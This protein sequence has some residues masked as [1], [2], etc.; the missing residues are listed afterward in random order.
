MIGETDI[1]MTEIG[2]TTGGTGGTTGGTIE[3]TGT[4]TTVTE[5][6][7]T[8]I[9]EIATEE[10]TE[11]EKDSTE[12]EGTVTEGVVGIEEGIGGTWTE[13]GA[14]QVTL[15]FFPF[16][17]LHLFFIFFPFLSLSPTSNVS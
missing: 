14:K 3:G 7:M 15:H 4:G 5:E 1:R 12:T 2:K 10:R 8:E 13:K 9:D 17:L 16:V 11:T 6:T